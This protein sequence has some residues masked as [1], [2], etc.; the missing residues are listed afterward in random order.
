MFVRENHIRR[1]RWTDSSNCKGQ[2][3]QQVGWHS[4]PPAPPPGRVAGCGAGWGALF[5]QPAVLCATKGQLCL[6]P[7]LI[8]LAAGVTVIAQF[9]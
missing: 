4:R 7:D 9:P 6:F 2:K 1:T 3:M 5:L 8:T